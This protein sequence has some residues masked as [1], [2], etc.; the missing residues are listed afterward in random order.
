MTAGTEHDIAGTGIDDLMGR[1]VRLRQ[2]D[3]GYR[4]GLDAALL[5]ACRA[6]TQALGGNPG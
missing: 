4:A 2:P 6:V 1:R 3:R 5:A